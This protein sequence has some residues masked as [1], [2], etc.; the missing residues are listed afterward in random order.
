MQRYPRS[1]VSHHDGANGAGA[2]RVVRD[3]GIAAAEEPGVAM[4][5]TARRATARRISRE[6]S[7]T[8]SDY[9]LAP[10]NLSASGAHEEMEEVAE[11][12]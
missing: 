6:F 2:A 5:I 12:P 3:S 8:G 4:R 1:V 11:G 9:R 7:R 10:I